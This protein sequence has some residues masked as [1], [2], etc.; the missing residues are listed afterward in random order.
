[1]KNCVDSNYTY[2]LEDKL[3]I[4]AGVKCYC[5]IVHQVVD[6]GKG[7]QMWVA[8]NVNFSS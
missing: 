7:L 1:M 6:G 2:K 5:F 4:R 3:F 8:V